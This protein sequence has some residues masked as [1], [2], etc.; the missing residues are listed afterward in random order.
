M[1]LLRLCRLNGLTGIPPFAFGLLT[2]VREWWRPGMTIAL[3]RPGMEMGG[4]EVEDTDAV[5]RSLR[6]VRVGPTAPRMSP[7]PPIDPTSDRSDGPLEGARERERLRDVPIGE[8]VC[9]ACAV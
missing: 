1:V 5:R 2:F 3:G 7:T 8:G 4:G 9:R 6:A